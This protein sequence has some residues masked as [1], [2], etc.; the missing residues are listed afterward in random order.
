MT[1]TFDTEPVQHVEGRDIRSSVAVLVGVLLAALVLV[2][3]MFAGGDRD[4]P[5]GLELTDGGA[6][7]PVEVVVPKIGVRSSLIG[8]GVNDDGTLQVPSL[9]TPM[10]ASWYTGG[11]VPG[12]LGPAV[13]LGHVD[14]KGQP[15]VFYRLRELQAGDQVQV[16]RADGSMATFTVTGLRQ[17]PKEQFP[18]GEVY[19][20]TAEPEL[21]LITCG[22]AFDASSG[23]YVDN[24]IVYA[25]L[26]DLTKVA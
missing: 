6:I 18:T 14:G 16:R 1:D 25:K 3:W 19:G 5:A 12:E 8:L 9:D 2:G 26:T 15:G 23:N 20:D 10:Q 11:V 13:V 24:V 17:V 22:G 21:R 7:A 4:G